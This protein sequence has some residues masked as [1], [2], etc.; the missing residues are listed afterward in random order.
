MKLRK[1]TGY[2]YVNCRKALLQFGDKNIDEAEKWLQELAEKEGWQKATE[3]EFLFI[4]VN[5]FV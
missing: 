2:S 3:Y 5:D 4:N 1:K